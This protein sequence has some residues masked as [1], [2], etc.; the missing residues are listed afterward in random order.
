M[1]KEIKNKLRFL[2]KKKNILKIVTNSKRGTIKVYNQ[3]GELLLKKANLTK[4]QVE[5][6]EDSFLGY[7]T[8]KL[9]TSERKKTKRE[10]FDPMVA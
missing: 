10:S 4:E 8:N 1:V 6:I 5:T 3:K 2:H 7:I 9:N